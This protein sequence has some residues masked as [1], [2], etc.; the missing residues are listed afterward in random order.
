LGFR[1][2]KYNENQHRLEY[3]IQIAQINA[4][5][6]REINENRQSF[7][8]HI[9]HEFRTP[10]TLI[11]NPLKEMIS[12]TTST[13]ERL[14]KLN[15]VYQNSKR[16]LS[17]VDQLL[18]FRKT[19]SDT[20]QLIISKLNVYQLCED[21]FEFF[22]EQAKVKQLEYTFHCNNPALEIWGDKEKLEIVLYNLLSNALKYS[23]DQG[24]VSMQVKDKKEG[25][26][27]S[28][29]DSGAGIPGGLGDKLFEKYFRADTNSP[30]HTGFGIGL[31]LVKQITENMEV[32][33]PI[34]PK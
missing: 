29:T 9:T 22:K 19:E 17:L 8:T 2:Y 25:V 32:K 28:I 3:E 23:A 1:F 13:E 26:E 6:E 18:L 33:F 12:H 7:F 21:A 14:R 31:Y 11:I 24:T 20:G 27:I 16:L 10:L 5:K 34:N 30:K 15:F 4:E